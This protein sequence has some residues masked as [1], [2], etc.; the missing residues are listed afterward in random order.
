M[1]DHWAEFTFEM[2]AEDPSHATMVCKH[3]YWKQEMEVDEVEEIAGAAAS[4]SIADG[5]ADAAASMNIA[6][7]S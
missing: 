4:M 5:I 6:D 1:V 2:S 7:G 3:I